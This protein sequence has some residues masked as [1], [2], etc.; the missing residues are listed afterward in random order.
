MKFEDLPIEFDDEEHN[1]EWSR[2]TRRKGTVAELLNIWD[3]DDPAEDSEMAQVLR[4]LR[5]L[6]G[7]GRKP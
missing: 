6:C 5:K 1:G 4:Y 7:E 2:P 3:I